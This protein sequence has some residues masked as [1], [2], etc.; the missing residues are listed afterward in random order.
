MIDRKAQ[1]K[2]GETIAIMFIFFILLIVG[3]VFYMNIQRTTVSRD[4]QQNYELRAVELSQIISFLPELQC[5]EANVVTASCFDIDKILGLSAVI[6]N[7]K[8][9]SALLLYDR[10]FGQVKIEVQRI[11]PPAET[12][13]LYANEKP[14]YTS[15]PVTHIPIS[16]FNASSGKRS[17]GVLD[18][19][20]YS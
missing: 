9:A 3:S 19:T 5:T 2:M 10:E 8:D 16:L 1:V 6:N 15:A 7:P 20:V 11:Y 13:H 4:I 12:I 18:I 17:F 14:G